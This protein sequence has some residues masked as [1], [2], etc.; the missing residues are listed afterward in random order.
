[1][2]APD[3]ARLRALAEAATAGPWRA[4]RNG[5]QY[6]HVGEGEHGNKLVGTSRIVELERPWNPYAGRK[7]DPEVVRL[8]NADADYIAALS[9]D[10]ALA[11]LAEVEAGREVALAFKAYISEFGI[12]HGG[13]RD[14]DENDYPCPED[15]TCRCEHVE[16]INR[17]IAAHDAAR[18]GGA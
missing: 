7:D 1:M 16:H 15:D 17:V 14:E 8:P 6:I 4:M 9:P 12:E 13:E 11:L 3:L 18:A 5:N 10:V 2:T